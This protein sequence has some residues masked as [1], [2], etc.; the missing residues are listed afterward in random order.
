[1]RTCELQVCC[2]ASPPPRN[3]YMR[4]ESVADTFVCANAIHFGMLG[5][6]AQANGGLF[7]RGTNMIGRGTQAGQITYDP[8]PADRFKR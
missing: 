6:I 1:M 2:G 7:V 3:A 8:G 4:V 5:V